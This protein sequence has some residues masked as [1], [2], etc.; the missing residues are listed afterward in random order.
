MA[1]IKRACGVSACN[2]DL[3]D[4]YAAYLSGPARKDRCINQGVHTKA[5][6]LGFRVEARGISSG[7]QAAFRSLSLGFMLRFL[8]CWLGLG[9]LD[10]WSR[11]S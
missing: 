6:V 4:Y 3:S 8:G 11:L 5:Q 7:I 9:M 1:S 2:V 10:V